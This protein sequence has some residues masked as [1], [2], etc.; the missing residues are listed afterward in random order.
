MKIY[1]NAPRVIPKPH[2][3]SVSRSPQVAEK[4]PAVKPTPASR[5]KVNVP[6]GYKIQMGLNQK[7][8]AFFE[9]LYPKA[10]KEIQKYLQNQNAQPPVKGQI[11]D[12]RG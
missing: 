9:K 6:N 1:G 3:T 8:Q 10:R 11:I 7:E 4:S 2:T 5:K 12:M